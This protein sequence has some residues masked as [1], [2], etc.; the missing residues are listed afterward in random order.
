MSQAHQV[1]VIIPAAGSGRRMQSDIPKQ[2]LPLAGRKVIEHTLERFTCNP[3][4]SGV[5][6]CLSDDDQVFS[7][8][9]VDNPQKIRTTPGGRERV[10]SVLNGLLALD[11]LMRAR[12]WVMVHDAARPC[13][14]PADIDELLD[15]GLANA[16]GALLAVPVRDTL[17][18]VEDGRIECTTDR[19]QLWHALTPQLF[20]YHALRDAIE[21]SLA[22]G[23][24]VTDEAQAMELAGFHP[25]VV[26]GRPDNIKITHPRDLALAQIF[27]AAQLK[28]QA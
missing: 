11:P 2:Y 21:K 16:D 10:H 19:S 12:D 9:Q 20:P 22:A 23:A 24:V 7:S 17:K 1:W 14:H 3:R 25:R 5:M 8:L 15:N 13:V 4:I 27:L 28:E 18:R 6:V 26:E